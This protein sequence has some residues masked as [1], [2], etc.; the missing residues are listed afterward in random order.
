KR[1]TVSGGPYGFVANPTAT[2]YADV[3]VTNGTPYYY[4]VS[5]TNNVAESANSVEVSATPVAAPIV[6]VVGPLTNGQFTLQF[7][8]VDGRTY[9]VQ[10]STNLVDWAGIYTNQQAG[11]LFIYTNTNATDAVRFYRVQQ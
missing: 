10:T 1:S 8:G 7:S 11:A 4:V 9:I 2:N 3:G 6:L 5:G